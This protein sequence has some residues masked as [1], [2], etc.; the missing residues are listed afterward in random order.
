[1]SYD[2]TRRILNP[3]NA[4]G[5]GLVSIKNE[6]WNYLLNMFG[7]K[8]TWMD[9][10]D[11]GFLASFTMIFLTVSTT[12]Y[13]DSIKERIKKSQKYLLVV[14]SLLTALLIF[15]S[16]YVQWSPYAWKYINGVQGRYFL[17]I[18]PLALFL[19]GSFRIK[20]DNQER[21]LKM[22]YSLGLF[23][24]AYAMIST[25]ITYL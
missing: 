2:F 18:M 19:L 10:V 22:I 5:A 17:P 1:M 24:S 3:I 9:K 12:L 16:I 20:Y 13:D 23:P 8:I 11:C 25:F 6:S 4:I 7:N 21:I 15:V 14:I